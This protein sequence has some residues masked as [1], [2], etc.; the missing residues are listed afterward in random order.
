MKRAKPSSL[1]AVVIFLLLFFPTVFAGGYFYNHL[2]DQLLDHVI[3]TRRSLAGLSAAA[4]SL[5]LNTLRELCVKYASDPE[6]AAAAASGDWQGA[7]DRIETLLEHPDY[8]DYYVERFVLVD[9]S[10]I[11]HGGYPG[12]PKS[13]I[14]AKDPALSS[15]TKAIIQNQAASYVSNVKKNLAGTQDNVIE[16]AAPIKSDGGII[17]FMTLVIPTNDFSDFGKEINVDSTG[18]AYIVDGEGHIVTH[19]RY[20]SEGSI[21]DYSHV[22]SVQQLLTNQSGIGINYNAIESQKRIVAF[23]KIPGF[24]WGVV[25]QQPYQEA[26]STGNSLLMK[27]TILTSILSILELIFAWALAQ[28]IFKTYA[29]K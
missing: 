10:G 7:V 21:V 16:V 15:W 13:V 1:L 12:L 19:P 11:I 2:E 6:L 3:E 18:F 23:E 28:I 25:A 20:P 27:I 9:P 14:G 29:K 22:S 4:V 8:Y 5:K 24:D 17:A 26:M